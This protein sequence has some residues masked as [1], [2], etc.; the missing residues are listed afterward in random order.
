[1]AHIKRKLDQANPFQDTVIDLITVDN[2]TN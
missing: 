2:L 1:M